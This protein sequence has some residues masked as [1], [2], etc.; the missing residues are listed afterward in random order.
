MSDPSRPPSLEERTL[1]AASYLLELTPVGLL[2]AV[3]VLLVKGGTSRF[4]GVHATQAIL[5][6]IALRITA[7]LLPPLTVFAPSS[8]GG[9][10]M[11]V[12]NAVAA[13]FPT[14]VTAWL[15]L[16][17]LHGRRPALPFLGRFSE[18]LLGP[19]DADL[20]NPSRPT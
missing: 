19:P 8:L 10:T 20:G 7:L 2:G 15:G 17:A 9:A 13:A 11:V 12:A 1:G 4:L 18:R 5:V 16:S 6:T 14:V 3:L